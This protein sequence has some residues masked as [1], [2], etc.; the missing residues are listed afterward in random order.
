MSEY[1]SAFVEGLQAALLLTDAKWKHHL[2][3]MQDESLSMDDREQAMNCTIILGNLMCDIKITLGKVRKGELD[4]KKILEAN[5]E[6]LTAL[7][8]EEF[9]GD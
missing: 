8:R 6:R 5:S 3:N 9:D 7:P 1:I 2:A 4:P